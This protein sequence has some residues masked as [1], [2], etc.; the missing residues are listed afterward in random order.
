MGAAYYRNGDWKSAIAALEKSM[1]LKRG[2]NSPWRFQ[3]HNWFFLAMSHWQ[4]G[5][6][7]EARRRF[8]QA[9]QKMNERATR[10]A[11]LSRFRAEA[12][13]LLGVNDQPAPRPSSRPSRETTAPTT[14]VSSPDARASPP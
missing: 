3:C 9:T 5:N 7:D 6:R 8:D 11:E 4:L 10:N 2:G 12:A 14:A 1:E 13:E